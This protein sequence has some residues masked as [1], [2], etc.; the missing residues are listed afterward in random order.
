MITTSSSLK[1]ITDP[2]SRILRYFYDPVG[3]LIKTVY[4]NGNEIYYD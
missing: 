2:L 1:S 4:P 3:N